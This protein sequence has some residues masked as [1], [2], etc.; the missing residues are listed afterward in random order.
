MLLIFRF[1]N[2]QKNKT[3]PQITIS[4]GGIITQKYYKYT[5]SSV[6]FICYSY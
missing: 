4:S 1:F 5:V 6:A 2:K 3:L